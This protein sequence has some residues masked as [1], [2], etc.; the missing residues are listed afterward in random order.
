MDCESESASSDV[1]PDE[2]ALNSRP[3]N[4]TDFGPYL[5]LA[6]IAG[7]GL[8]LIATK[9]IKVN[10]SIESEPVT[11]LDDVAPILELFESD[12]NSVTKESKTSKQTVL[13][14]KFAKLQ[15]EEDRQGI[16][17]LYKS[18][19]S[20][21]PSPDDSLTSLTSVFFS[22][23]FELF[24]NLN[25]LQ[26]FPRLSRLNHSCRPNCSIVGARAVADIRDIEEGEEVCFSYLRSTDNSTRRRGV[27][28]ARWGFVC[29]C[30][31]CEPAGD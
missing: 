15:F 16:L 11:L 24:P 26:L 27:L 22:N 23:S 10:T 21:S 7:K 31:R 1:D 13:A 4:F 28:E 12:Y 18:D 14:S 8:G 3:R 2:L 17:S 30:E 29:K 6:E 25:A 5:R 20:P 9:Q 19:H